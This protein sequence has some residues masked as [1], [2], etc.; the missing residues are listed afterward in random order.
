LGSDALENRGEDEVRLNPR[1]VWSDVAAFK[2][3]LGGED[4]ES[5]LQLYRGPLLEGFFLSEAPEFERWLSDER[6]NL[7]A[8]AA[9]GAFRLAETEGA[10]GNLGGSGH[11]VRRGLS[12]AP[13]DERLVKT[14]M[15][16]LDQAG[17]RA[18]AL[19]A[20][21]A[22]TNRLREELDLSPTE[23]T[24][25][26]ASKI[27]ERR[28]GSR[29]DIVGREAMGEALFPGTSESPSSGVGGLRRPW[30]ARVL[31]LAAFATITTIAILLSGGQDENL[32]A[33]GLTEDQH[34]GA[35]TGS[36]SPTVLAVLPFQPHGEEEGTPALAYGVHEEVLT[37]LSK[38]P[39][40][41]V[42]SRR[43]VEQLARTELTLPEIALRLGAG[44]ILEGSVQR[45][46]QQVRISVQLIDANSDTHLWAQTFY[47]EPT[48]ILELQLE[49]AL[50]VTGTLRAHLMANREGPVT[51]S[52][53]EALSEALLLEAMT[54][55][56]GGGPDTR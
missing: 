41:T 49:I 23:E 43:S 11:W 4:T 21:A 28:R 34:P 26:L 55:G 32:G 51:D 1:A 53:Q 39:G 2:S 5:G 38:V 24:K 47:R 37:Y 6:E 13:L 27:S 3:A 33:G 14:G 17:D 18:G 45:D 52:L 9:A 42:I 46:G 36:L 16:L 19:Q 30:R 48:D 29:G 10:E 22:F 15:A 40:L 54:G 25:E 56:R 35:Q 44:S 31:S 8:A 20:Y 7:R 12:L 50:R